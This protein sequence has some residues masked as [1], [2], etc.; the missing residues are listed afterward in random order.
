MYG[1]RVKEGTNKMKEKCAQYKMD[2]SGP[3]DVP[4]CRA[5]KVIVNCEGWLTGCEYPD[6]FIPVR[7]L[8]ARGTITFKKIPEPMK[9]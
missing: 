4:Y 3:L 1:F 8:P 9:N 7:A 2:L 6:L 5:K